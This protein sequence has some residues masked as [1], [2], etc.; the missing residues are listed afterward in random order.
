LIF[1]CYLIAIDQ[2]LANSSLAN[3]RIIQQRCRFYLRLSLIFNDLQKWGF[4][5]DCKG[6]YLLIDGRQLLIVFRMK[7]R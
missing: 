7:L 6:F 4:A 2:L 3:I 5:Y 1:R